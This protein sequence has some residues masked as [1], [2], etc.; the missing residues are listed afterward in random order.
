MVR[1]LLSLYFLYFC[2]LFESR[3]KIDLESCMRKRSHLILI[4]G[5]EDKTGSKLILKKIVRTVR[6]K[7][8]ALIP[9]ATGYPRDMYE[10]Y[11]DAFRSLGVEDVLMM[12]IRYRDE[13]DREEHFRT[14]DRS[15]M[16]FIG[17][18]DQVKLLDIFAHSR[19]LGEIKRRFFSG[20]LPVAGT[21][22]GAA[23][24][25]SP[26][27]YDGDYRGF[28][29]GEVKGTEGLGFIEG[30]AIDTHFLQRER[31]PRLTQF[32]LKEKIS[33]AIGID[34]DTAIFIGSDLRAKVVGS[35][36]V[37]V[38]NTDKVNYSDL[39]S[40]NDRALLTVNNMRVGFL[41][42]GNTFSIKRWSVLKPWAAVKKN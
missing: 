41:S 5:A 6:P 36:M 20:T 7:N 1:S 31:I 2:I 27:I 35:N 24:A 13:V 32:V 40:I 34:E 21:S 39:N 3:F 11:Y 8:I 33:K 12:D 16:I 22:A 9:T 30:V 14:L 42:P 4:G 25:C 29:R 15:D 37:T 19:L 10:G 23:A 38:L 26:M 28:E 17:G 18:G